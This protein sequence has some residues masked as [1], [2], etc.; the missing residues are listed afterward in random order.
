MPILW[1][2]NLQWLLPAY[3]LL[4]PVKDITKEGTHTPESWR[5]WYR[6]S[7]N[8]LKIQKGNSP[9]LSILSFLSTPHRVYPSIFL[10]SCVQHQRNLLISYSPAP[11]TSLLPLCLPPNWPLPILTDWFNQCLCIPFFTDGSQDQYGHRVVSWSP[12]WQ[13]EAH[14][15]EWGRKTQGQFLNV[16]YVP[17]ILLDTFKYTAYLYLS[18]FLQSVSICKEYCAWANN[19]SS[20]HFAKNYLHPTSGRFNS[21]LHTYASNLG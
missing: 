7:K 13:E 9:F 12:C 15:W 5:P 17:G 10:N 6:S 2:P 14:Q 11:A 3:S 16:H 21:F 1:G 18:N 19:E 4:C 20:Y 8:A